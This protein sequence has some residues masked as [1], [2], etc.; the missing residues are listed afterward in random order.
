MPEVD[1]R[2]FT[3]MM[4][5][6]HTARRMV[7]E[8]ARRLEADGYAGVQPAYHALFE[9]I[10][11]EG[12]RLTE[13][14]ARAD[15]T[16]QSMGELVAT[17]E[18]RGWVD[19]ATGPQRRPGAAGLPH[20]RGRAAHPSRAAPHQRDR[21]RVAAALARGRLRAERCATCSSRRSTTPRAPDPHTTSAAT[22]VCAS[23]SDSP[24]WWP[25]KRM[26]KRW[27]SRH[28][29]VSPGAG[30]T[31]TS[32][33]RARRR[34]PTAPSQP[35]ATR[36]AT[37]CTVARSPSRRPRPSTTSSI[38]PGRQCRKR[39]RAEPAG[40]SGRPSRPRAS[41]LDDLRPCLV[42]VDRRR[43]VD[44]DLPVVGGQ[45]DDRSLGQ[46]AQPGVQRVEAAL[47]GGGELRRR[48]PVLVARWSRPRP[49]RRRRTPAPARRAGWRASSPSPAASVAIGW[50]VARRAPS[51]PS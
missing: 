24:P 25:R 4:A 34:A 16:H 19:G 48:R 15:M 29:T 37:R 49:S 13:L 17:L 30:S 2:P 3:V 8:L 51:T 20:A 10:D 44:V 18:R 28:H 23:S 1:Q 6:R 50:I 31:Q 11:V 7:E 36:S 39:S 5:F 45:Q 33:S 43:R 12:T 41:R 22:W 35:A 27:R 42:D 38:A 47:G 21:G 46:R 40:A 26:S 9:N 14:A 32:A